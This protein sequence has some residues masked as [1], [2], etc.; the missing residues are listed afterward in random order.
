MKISDQ[1]N[2]HKGLEKIQNKDGLLREIKEI[3]TNKHLS[4]GSNSPKEI[5]NKTNERFNQRGWADKVRVGNSNLTISFLK[6]KVGICFQIGN[7][8]R[9]YADILKL[10]QLSKKGII[11]AG[12]IIVPQTL[13]S[14]MMGANYAQFD[15]LVKELSHFNEI[16]PTPILVIGLSN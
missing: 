13:E 12:V 7:V 15:R 16:V 10:T 8:A 3:I 14:K 2:H 5:K 11:D 4:F 6:G 9:T 1:Y